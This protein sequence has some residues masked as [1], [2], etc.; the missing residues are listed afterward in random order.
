MR[1]V[2]RDGVIESQDPSGMCTY[3]DIPI[4]DWSKNLPHARSRINLFRS[5]E[6][7]RN[8]S[9]FKVEAKAGILSLAESMV[10]MS[11]SRHRERLNGHY[12][13]SV[14]SYSQLFAAKIKE[15][16]QNNPFWDPALYLA[17]EPEEKPPH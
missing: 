11:T 10:V 7:A 4:R 17:R 1:V 3:V 2:L 13:S 5:E 6:H 14:A 8:W 9:G 15:V 16:T 12:V